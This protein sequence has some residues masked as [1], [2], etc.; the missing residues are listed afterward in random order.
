MGVRE[1]QYFGHEFRIQYGLYGSW[2]S[3]AS[4]ISTAKNKLSTSFNW[5]PTI[6]G[7]RLRISASDL[8]SSLLG[9][10]AIDGAWKLDDG[11]FGCDVCLLLATTV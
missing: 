6:H 10:H 8:E 9:I 2:H 3:L 7:L 11:R 5:T 1:H 4:A